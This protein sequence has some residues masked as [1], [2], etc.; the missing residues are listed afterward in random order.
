MHDL[1]ELRVLP[2]LSGLTTLRSSEISLCC[3]LEAL[4]SGFG[5]MME[6]TND[7]PFGSIAVAVGYIRSDCAT[8]FDDSQL[9]PQFSGGKDATKKIQGYE[10]PQGAYTERLC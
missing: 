10:V 5:E 4:P 9:R 3:A 2:D 1:P 8:L 6:E 7:L